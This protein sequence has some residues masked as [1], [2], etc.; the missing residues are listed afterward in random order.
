MSALFLVIFLVISA[1]VCIAAWLAHHFLFGVPRRG[2]LRQLEI[3]A[4]RP[5]NSASGA[6]LLLSPNI[7]PVGPFAWLP[8]L[9]SALELRAASAGLDWSGPFILASAVGLA[10]AGAL[11]GYLFPFLIFR[12]LSTAVLALILGSLPF[13]VLNYHR[14]KRLRE[15][16][17]QFPEALDFIARALRAGHAFSVSLEMLATD[18]PPPLSTEFRR[19]FQELNL[20]A[21]IEPTLLA[22][23]RR[24]PLVDVKFF[25]SAVLLQREAGGNLS[26]ILTNLAHT[27][28]ERFRLKGH[29]RAATAHARIS[30]TVLTILPLVVLIGL[31]IRSPK[32]I[33]G[34]VTDPL[35][36]YLLVGALFGQITG[37]L[38]MRK[39]INFRI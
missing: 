27:V 29:V 13:L 17:E 4:D 39:L 8:N 21:S 28:R 15:F 1:I 32:Y 5:T 25:A 9:A 22:F 35:G 30:A 33:A 10:L 36:P 16:E 34:F 31:Q 24:V 38:L 14:A 37:Y 12:W 6:D 11:A 19:I 26:E 18:S 7:T 3:D 2:M 23:A 20:G